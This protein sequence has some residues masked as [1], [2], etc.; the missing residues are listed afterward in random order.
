MA[1]L[2]RATKQLFREASVVFSF[3]Y[4]CHLLFELQIFAIADIVY[5]RIG[6]IVKKENMKLGNPNKIGYYPDCL[7]RENTLCSIFYF[8]AI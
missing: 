2:L 8:N 3:D 5:I 7:K 6:N 4:S 1:H